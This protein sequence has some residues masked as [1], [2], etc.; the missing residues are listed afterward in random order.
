[1][2]ATTNT[3]LIEELTAVD[4]VIGCIRLNRPAAF[5]ALNAE[6]IVAI[7]Q[8]LRQ[9]QRRDDV[10][11]VVI[12]SV[13]GRAFCAGGDIRAL[14]DNQKDNLAASLRFFETEY[15]LNYLIGSYPKPIV[16]MVDGIVMGGG[17]GLA[18]HSSHRIGTENTLF[19]MPETGIGLFPDIGASYFLQKCPGWLRV[20]LGLTGTRLRIADCCYAKVIDYFVPSNQLAEVLAALCATS[21]PGNARQAVSDVILNFAV[22]PDEAP[23]KAHQFLID[24][25]FSTDTIED[26]LRYLENDASPWAQIVAEHL[27]QKSPLSLKVTLEALRRA[28]GCSLGDCLRQDFHLAQ[29]FLTSHDLYEGIRAVLIDKDMQPQWQ[30]TQLGDVSDSDCDTYF[31]THNKKDLLLD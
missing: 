2:T 31:S 8:C 18:M 30:P 24:G 11:A 25:I 15:R 3:V 26:M 21:L 27:Q 6:M 19:A 16:S 12:A 22:S 17:A 29:S 7:D 23:L 1:M 20:F 14:Y 9:W 5:N 4:G 28:K 10:A 13:P